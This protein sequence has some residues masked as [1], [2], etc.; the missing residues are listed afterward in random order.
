MFLLALELSCFGEDVALLAVDEQEGHVN[1]MH[2]RAD[3]VEPEPKR[4]P[5][6]LYQIFQAL[7]PEH[8][9]F[10]AVGTQRCNV[11]F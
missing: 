8:L 10:I 4:V 3:Q 9:N 1:N 11:N 5:F 6:E 7:R 2:D